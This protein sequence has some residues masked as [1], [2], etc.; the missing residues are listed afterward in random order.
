[1]NKK[2]WILI[3]ILLGLV[4]TSIFLTK[5]K[6]VVEPPIKVEGEEI[7]GESTENCLLLKEE[8]ENQLQDISSLRKWY[9]KSPNIEN[10]TVSVELSLPLE[11]FSAKYVLNEQEPVDA[12]FQQDRWV[13]NIPVDQLESR[14]Y[15]LRVECSVCE[16]VITKEFSFNVS[17]PVYVVWS[18][19][20]EGFD[21]KEDYLKEMANISTKYGVPMTHFFNPYIY[22]NVY[23]MN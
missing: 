17:N 5:E 21:V 15:R 14:E 11:D 13:V 16:E 3:L 2:L 22:R 10:N 8:V 18:I 1:M 6:P 7:K 12:T 23:K 4:S 20:W 9:V 19:D